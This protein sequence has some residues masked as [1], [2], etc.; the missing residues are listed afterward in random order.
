MEHIKGCLMIQAKV[1]GR[2]VNGIAVKGICNHF[3]LDT[4]R[5]VGIGHYGICSRHK[6]VST[7]FAEKTLLSA[8]KS[9]SDDRLCRAVRTG[10]L[11]YKLF[12]LQYNGNSVQQRRNFILRKLADMV[13][14]QFLLGHGIILLL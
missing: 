10:W 9:V 3:F 14:K 11:G 1:F 6:C 5:K 7:V 12:I 13:N 8:L 4:S 2:K